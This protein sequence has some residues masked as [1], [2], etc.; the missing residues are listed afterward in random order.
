MEDRDKTIV[1]GGLESYD[2]VD[3]RYRGGERLRVTR[4]C[5]VGPTDG[6]EIFQRR[7]GWSY[8]VVDQESYLRGKM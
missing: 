7:L 6:E 8:H 2:K 4:T 5:W 1:I 3:G